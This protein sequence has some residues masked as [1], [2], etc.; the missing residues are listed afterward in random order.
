MQ[1]ENRSAREKPAEASLDWKLIA[2]YSAETGYRSRDALVQS[3]RSTASLQA[4]PYE[5]CSL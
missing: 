1:E 5:Q 2:H 3:E 4:S